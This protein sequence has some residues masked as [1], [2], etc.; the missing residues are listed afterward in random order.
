MSFVLQ[1]FRDTTYSQKQLLS[2]RKVQSGR[3]MQGSMLTH[4]VYFRWGANVNANK[5][6]VSIVFT[7]IG[8]FKG[9]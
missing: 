6:R 4:I 9:R 5:C 7:E 8:R 3:R 2:R 1:N